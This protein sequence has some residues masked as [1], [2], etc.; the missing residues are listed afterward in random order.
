MSSA[1]YLKTNP[2]CHRSNSLD[3]IDL[4]KLDNIFQTKFNFYLSLPL[5]TTATLSPTL[6]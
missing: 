6:R 5:T 3:Q 2:T 4:Q 1:G